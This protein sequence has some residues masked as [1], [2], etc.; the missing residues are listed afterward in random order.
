VNASDYL[1]T[2]A[3]ANYILSGFFKFQAIT[4]NI[5]DVFLWFVEIAIVYKILD[6]DIAG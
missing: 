5:E 3:D 2:A 1:H 6:S 4:P